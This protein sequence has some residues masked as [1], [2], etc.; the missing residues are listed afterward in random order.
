MFLNE[1]QTKKHLIVDKVVLENG[2]PSP[3]LVLGFRILFYSSSS[4]LTLYVTLFCSLESEKLNV[5]IFTSTM[6]PPF[7]SPECL[8]H[9]HFHTEG[10]YG[11]SEDDQ[12]RLWASPLTIYFE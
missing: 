11:S 1:V 3:S 12:L 9:S 7:I 2:E 8:S 5:L 6:P 4:M 10:L